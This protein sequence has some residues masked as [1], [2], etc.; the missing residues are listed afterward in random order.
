MN[1]ETVAS[2]SGPLAVRQGGSANLVDN[3][4]AVRE[5]LSR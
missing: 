2:S 3:M 5:I 1:L 4:P